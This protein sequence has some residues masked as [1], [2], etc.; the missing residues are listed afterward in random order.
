MEEHLFPSSC[1]KK[2]DSEAESTGFVIA[3]PQLKIFHYVL[4]ESGLCFFASYTHICTY[5]YIFLYMYI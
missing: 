2:Y 3:G 5:L 1:L 4:C